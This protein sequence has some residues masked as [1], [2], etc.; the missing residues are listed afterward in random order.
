MDWNCLQYDNIAL[1]H[2]PT[3]TGTVC[4][5]VILHCYMFAQ[6]LELFAVR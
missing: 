2:V 4:S 5:T 1:L 3:D 6:G